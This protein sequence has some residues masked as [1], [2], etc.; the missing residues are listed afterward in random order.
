[1]KYSLAGFNGQ[2]PDPVSGHS[3]LGNGYRAYS[4][5][6]GRFTT[7]DSWSPF[8]AGGINPY[9]YCAGDPV[10]RA[11]PSGHFSLGQGIGMVLGIAA[12]IALSALT[13]GLALG[14]ALSLLANVAADAAIGA[15][16]ELAA[17]GI[18]GQ[19]VNGDQVGFAA[20]LGA[21]TSLVGFG[22]AS[23]EMGGF[24]AAPQ[25]FI[26]LGDERNIAVIM[27]SLFSR[28]IKGR[29][30][31]SINF[32]FEDTYKG[33]ARLNIVAHGHFHA[34]T[35]T[36]RVRFGDPIKRYGGS[37]FARYLEEEHGVDYS[38]YK[39]ARLL[40]CSAASTDGRF[41]SFAG[42]FA[43]YSKL[44][45]KS[46]DGSVTIKNDIQKLVDQTYDK[47]TQNILTIEEVNQ[48]VALMKNN[49]QRPISIMKNGEDNSEYWPV[50][51]NEEGYEVGGPRFDVGF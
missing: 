12:G 47:N 28:N 38:K 51:F 25:D 3:H 10:N 27:P 33:E 39:S 9:A 40:I 22:L 42:K 48:S 11:D 24:T 31:T 16:S 19:R 2:R 20:A 14:P 18:D 6:L 23:G 35:G 5:V 34:A 37:R 44:R 41:M 45:V 46:Y 15:G 43:K 13:E 21:V 26:R 29:A 36:S 1:M 49:G 32:M 7:P 4:P 30:T 50:Y 17:S 8:G